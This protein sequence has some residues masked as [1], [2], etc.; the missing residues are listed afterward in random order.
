[1]PG[2]HTPTATD[3]IQAEADELVTELSSLGRFDAV[4]DLAERFGRWKRG[5][6]IGGGGAETA[7]AAIRKR[8]GR[9]A[10][11]TTAG[12]DGLLAAP[13]VTAAAAMGAPGELGS[14]GTL[15]RGTVAAPTLANTSGVIAAT[16]NTGVHV[17]QL[18]RRRI[19][20]G[21]GR[22]SGQTPNAVNDLH[23]E[24]GPLA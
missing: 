1:M 16:A 7:P 8:D 6:T 19:P 2:Q 21:R 15:N 20:V 14:V 9:R 13:V 12:P 10:G 4:G 18:A 5:P 24:S 11:A 17:I 23:I 3:F 22:F